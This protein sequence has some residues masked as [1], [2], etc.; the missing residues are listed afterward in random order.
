MMFSKMTHEL[1]LPQTD[2]VF[3]GNCLTSKNEMSTAM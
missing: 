1:K 3:E 2:G